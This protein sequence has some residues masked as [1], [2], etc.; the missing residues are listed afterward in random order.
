MTTLYIVG[1]VGVLGGLVIWLGFRHARKAGA[2]QAVAEGHEKVIK[3]AKK[4]ADARRDPDNK[5][6]RR[7]DRPK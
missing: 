1:L 5:R 4:A 3:N 2:S 6:V 7:F